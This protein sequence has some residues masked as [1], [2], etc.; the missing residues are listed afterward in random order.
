MHSAPRLRENFT[1]AASRQRETLS[2]VGPAT[3]DHVIRTKPKTL[4]R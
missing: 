4:V 2:Q 3:P 1:F